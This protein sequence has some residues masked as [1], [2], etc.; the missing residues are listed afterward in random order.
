MIRDAASKNDTPTKISTVPAKV[1]AGK[2][3]SG[4]IAKGFRH[5]MGLSLHDR[6]GRSGILANVDIRVME[7]GAW[8]RLRARDESGSH[9]T[10]GYKIEWSA[11]EL[12]G[13]MVL[14]VKAV[15]EGHRCQRGTTPEPTRAAKMR[16][17]RT[18]I[19][20]AIEAH[21]DEFVGVSCEIGGEG[22]ATFHVDFDA[23]THE[24][25]VDVDLT[26]NVNDR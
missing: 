26:T 25:T 5:T 9:D 13:G 21:R 18:I 12:E 20:E 6:H 19:F 24:F 8:K 15:A 3:L 23:E 10:G 16:R 14:A 11:V 4:I 7:P 22:E 2:K 1:K 17:L